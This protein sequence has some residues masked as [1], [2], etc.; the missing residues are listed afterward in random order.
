[1]DK[2]LELRA[3]RAEIVGEMEVILAAAPDDGDFT[4]EQTVAFDALRAED[5]KLATQ[6][7]THEDLERRRA[8]SATPVQPLPGVTPA[9]AGPA[10]VPAKPEEKGLTF[11]RMMRTLA[12][13]GG[14]QYVAQQLAEANGDSGLFANQNM[15]SGDAGGFLVPE[16]VSEEMIELLRPQS[17]VTA[18]GPRIVPMP[19]NSNMTTNR[20]ASGANIGYGGEQQDAPAAGYTY[21]QVKLSAKKLS[22]IIPISN[23]LLRTSSIAVDRMVRDDAVADA[24]QMQ[25]RHFLR[26]SGTEYS[27]KGLRFQIVGTPYE[28]THILTMT[29]SVDLKTLDT[30]LSTALHAVSWHVPHIS[31]DLGP[32]GKARVAGSRGGKD[33]PLDY[34]GG[35]A[36]DFCHAFIRSGNS[37]HG[38]A[39]ICSVCCVILG[40]ARATPP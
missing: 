4:D 3:R 38:R 10:S 17:V 1:M 35:A 16:D 29:G 22:G 24:S 9:S 14:N 36:V 11:A 30:V 23:D 18:M 12:A 31:L 19:N 37:C 2:I 32:D 27:P 20:R 25:D 33:H 8:A 13:A 15:G 34:S 6:L 40:K 28:A 21:G 7:A 26:G 39:A 5:D